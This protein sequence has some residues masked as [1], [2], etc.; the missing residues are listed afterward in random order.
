MEPLANRP[1]CSWGVC[2][3]PSAGRRGNS[4][5]TRPYGTERSIRRV[6][7]TPTD[8]PETP[9]VGG[10]RE[11][12]PLGRLGPGLPALCPQGP[13]GP[14]RSR[15]VQGSGRPQPH[16]K[17]PGRP[18]GPSWPLLGPWGSQVGSC[19]LQVLVQVSLPLVTRHNLVAANPAPPPF[20]VP[21]S[22]HPFP[23]L[24]TWTSGSSVLL[25]SVL[26]PQEHLPRAR[27]Q[28]TL[29]NG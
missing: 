15:S 17:K 26:R 22:C 19:I 13:R 14:N 28:H 27:P 3:G 20:S 18:R 29:S 8:K 7:N 16:G 21:H 9:G 11:G 24:C 25:P 4:G 12:Q 6:G 2:H 1:P 23:S 5:K 10:G